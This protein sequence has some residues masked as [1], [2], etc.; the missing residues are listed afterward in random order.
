M[1]V[2]IPSPYRGSILIAELV[3]L[4]CLILVRAVDTDRFLWLWLMFGVWI[5]FWVGV[6]FLVKFRVRPTIPELIALSFGPLAIFFVVFA[7][8]DY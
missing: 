8:G 6:Y 1:K 5:V 4:L 2:Q 3:Q 7:A